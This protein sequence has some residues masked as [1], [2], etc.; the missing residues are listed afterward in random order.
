MTLFPPM[1]VLILINRL[2]SLVVCQKISQAKKRCST[3]IV[4][5]TMIGFISINRLRSLINSENITDK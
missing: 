5:P 4:S 1:I 3:S 2:R